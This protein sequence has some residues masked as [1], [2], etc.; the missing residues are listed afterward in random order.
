MRFRLRL[1]TP[2]FAGF[3]VALALSYTIFQQPLGAKRLVLILPP[4]IHPNV[5]ARITVA[6]VNDL[7]Q[8]D[9]YREDLVEVSVNPCSHASL[10][11]EGAPQP[12]WNSPVTLRLFES[13]ATPIM[14]GDRYETVALTAR[15]IGEGPI[16]QFHTHSCIFLNLGITV[17]DITM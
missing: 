8:V 17:L 10:A 14:V 9:T 12:E 4:T 6:A 16:L 2:I 5:A 3:T 11:V 15:W 13:K 1:A 7:M